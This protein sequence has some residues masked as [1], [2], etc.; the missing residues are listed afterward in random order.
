MEGD[1]ALRHY[2]RCAH[3]HYSAMYITISVVFSILEQWRR[4]YIVCMVYGMLEKK[5]RF[6]SKFPDPLIPQRWMYSSRS[7]ND[8]TPNFKPVQHQYL[9]HAYF[10]SGD[11]WSLPVML[12]EENKVQNIAGCFLAAAQNNNHSTPTNAEL[13]QAQP[14]SICSLLFSSV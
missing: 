5:C 13:A 14:P 4:R 8:T 1:S 3:A 10:Q 7:G 9:L 6:S 2:R 12:E 11:T